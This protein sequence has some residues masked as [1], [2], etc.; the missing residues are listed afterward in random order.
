MCSHMEHNAKIGKLECVPCHTQQ[1]LVHGK[2]IHFLRWKVAGCELE[3]LRRVVT[4]V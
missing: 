3:Q 1:L 2:F 4:R